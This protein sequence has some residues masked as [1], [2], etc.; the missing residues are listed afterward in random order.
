MNAPA[1]SAEA[2]E[3]RGSWFTALVYDPML[4]L[5]ERAGMAERRARLLAGARGAVLEIGAGTGL[6]LER[7]PAGVERLVLTEPEEHMAKR[8]ARRV[9]AAGSEAEVVRASADALPFDDQSFDT[10]VSTMVLCT[11]PDPQAALGEISRV[12]R[13][14]G[15]L[16]FC[17][18]VRSEGE[19]L[20]R[21][22]DR[23]HGPWAAFADG[24]RC[25]QPTPEL[26]SD[27]GFAVEVSERDAWRR[28]PPLVRPLVAGH[29]QPHG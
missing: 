11:V 17:E 15:R 23:L 7:Y 9:A 5:G 18:H 2:P 29:A 20:A 26:L 3:A 19:R 12:L 4:W 1:A 24:C 22:Q 25:N 8:L 13:P 28:M 10:V 16:L 6:N 27:A 21:W 14:G